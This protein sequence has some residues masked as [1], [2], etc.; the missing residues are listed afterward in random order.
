[1]EEIVKLKAHA[2]DCLVSIESWQRELK[3]TVDQIQ[4]ITNEQSN[5]PKS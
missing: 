1:M 5:I 3:Q 2:Y 4:K